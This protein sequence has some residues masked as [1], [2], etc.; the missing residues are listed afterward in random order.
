MASSI[1]QALW[2]LIWKLAI[3]FSGMKAALEFAFHDFPFQ[4]Q[5]NLKCPIFQ[6]TM[7]K[8]TGTTTTLTFDLS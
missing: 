6:S 1:S 5:M 3:A 4:N 8:K 2:C 7:D